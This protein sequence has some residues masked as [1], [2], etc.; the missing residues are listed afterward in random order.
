LPTALRPRAVKERLFGTLNF[1]QMS[2]AFNITS[3]VRKET[4]QTVIRKL[5]NTFH[6]LEKIRNSLTH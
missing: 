3:L 5:R 4:K 6:V 2:A 1:L